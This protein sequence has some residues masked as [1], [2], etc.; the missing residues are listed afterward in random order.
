MIFKKL[1]G[2]EP[3]ELIPSANKELESFADTVILH[4]NQPRKRS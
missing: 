1:V 2:I 4:E 3:L